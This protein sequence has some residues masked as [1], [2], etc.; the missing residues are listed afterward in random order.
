MTMD[1]A[2]ERL[3]R[4]TL[5]DE[6]ET[7]RGRYPEWHGSPGQRRTHDGARPRRPAFG[8][9]VGVAALAALSLGLVVGAPAAPAVMPAAT[10]M[11]PDEPAVPIVAGQAFDAD[12]GAT[13]SVV[14]VDGGARGARVWLLSRFGEVRLGPL[15][16]P[17]PG[18]PP[19]ADASIWLASGS[20]RWVSDGR[21]VVRWS[22]YVVSVG[23]GIT[24]VRPADTV[25]HLL[26]AGLVESS[27]WQ[28]VELPAAGIP[29]GGDLVGVEPIPGG[30][31]LLT[32]ID[33]IVQ[34]LDDGTVV[35]LPLPTDRTVLAPT[36]EVTSFLTQAAE[37]GASGSVPTF[38]WG[39]DARELNIGDA[40]LASAP[41]TRE[42]GTAWVLRRDRGW[43][44]LRDRVYQ[45]GWEA[46]AQG[47]VGHEVPYAIDP[48]GDVV[49]MA[50]Q[51]GVTGTT[52]LVDRDTGVVLNAIDGMPEG[53]VAWFGNEAV[54]AVATAGSDG[55]P[56]SGGLVRLSPHGLERVSWDWPAPAGSP[57]R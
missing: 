19:G 2:V 8:A 25:Q 42:H 31:Y 30:G 1:R 44:A 32:G 49:L 57:T 16:G 5:A 39:P 9:L 24:E 29:S 55:E 11:P 40:V 52:S 56:A 6:L 47:P 36:N 20:D 34:V 7:A 4:E 45:P 37:P 51:Q 27:T 28:E 13:G 22:E 50:P 53:R 41:S 18:M 10:T 21:T 33:T 17:I 14:L 3:L 35:Q 46:V 38:L 54:F 12:T 43:V 26:L 23:D 48:A 15:V